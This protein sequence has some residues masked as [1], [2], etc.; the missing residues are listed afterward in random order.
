LWPVATLILL[1]PQKRAIDKDHTRL[2][3]LAATVLM[4]EF[5]NTEREIYLFRLRLIFIGIFVLACFSA[6]VT[7]FVWLQ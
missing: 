6:L 5:K 1:A 3:D 7:R 2:S 4:N